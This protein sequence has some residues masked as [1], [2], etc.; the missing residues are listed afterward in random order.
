MSGIQQNLI[1]QQVAAAAITKQVR[2]LNLL[3][4]GPSRERPMGRFQEL[5]GPFLEQTEI[6]PPDTRP[7]SFIF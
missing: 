1:D 2:L 5:H 7:C 3:K 6:G 4:I